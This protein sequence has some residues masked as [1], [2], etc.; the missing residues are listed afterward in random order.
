MPAV[1]Y[2]YAVKA[3]WIASGGDVGSYAEIEGDCR[4]FWLDGRTSL[5]DFKRKRHRDSRSNFNEIL[6][7]LRGNSS[8]LPEKVRFDPWEDDTGESAGKDDFLGT[9]WIDV[10]SA[11][12]STGRDEYD[13]DKVYKQNFHT[14]KDFAFMF[15]FEVNPVIRF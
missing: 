5:I 15:S 8:I 14:Y 3:T 12:A 10:T 11:Y 6:L 2:N 1:S 9:A 7:S 13:G 4:I